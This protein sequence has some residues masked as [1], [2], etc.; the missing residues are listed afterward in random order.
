MG[1]FQLEQ[2]YHSHQFVDSDLELLGSDTLV[3]VVGTGDR[4]GDGVEPGRV[5]GVGELRPLP[6]ATC[7]Q[8]L[9]LELVSPL[10]HLNDG[11]LSA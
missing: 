7:C 2:W 9:N 3:L 5:D 1:V 10:Q 6:I 4:R 8:V 11:G